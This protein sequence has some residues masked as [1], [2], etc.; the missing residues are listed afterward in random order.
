MQS[1]YAWL[2]VGACIAL[3]LIGVILFIKPHIAV[4][5]ASGTATTTS[6]TGSTTTAYLGNGITAT[7]P[8]GATIHVVNAPPSL[9]GSIQISSSL[10]ASA[11][12]ALQTQ[13]ETLIS[14]LKQTPT[15]LDLWLQLGV[16]RKIGGDYAGAI[17][18]WNYVAQTGSTSINYIAY[19]D[20][21]DLY[22]NFDT[23]YAQAAA[24]YQ[25]AI[26]INP[27]V[28]DYYVDLYNLYR[29]D[30][31]DPAAASAIL[32]AGLKANPNNAELQ[33]LQSN[34]TE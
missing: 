33:Q 1:N 13:E 24:S 11:Q 27:D 30:D 7:L 14:Q 28:P 25:A 5:P 26:A 22:Q 2:G 17:E 31:N 6:S 12:E 20:L 3:L 19:G 23:N 34:G 29:Y 8:A 9:T 18:A 10:P 4:A 16:D 15:R 32:Q 21:G